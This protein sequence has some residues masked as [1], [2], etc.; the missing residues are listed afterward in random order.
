MALPAAGVV[1]EAPAVGG[2]FSHQD[3]IGGYSCNSRKGSSVHRGVR[4]WLAEDSSMAV[5]L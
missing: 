1:P 3:S 2:S 5:L 4:P